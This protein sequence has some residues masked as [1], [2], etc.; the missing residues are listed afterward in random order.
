[1]PLTKE[2]LIQ[3]VLENVVG[4][5]DAIADRGV[6]SALQQFKPAMSP[7]AS[8]R[9]GVTGFR[10]QAGAAAAANQAAAQQEVLHGVDLGQDA[11]AASAQRAQQA[12]GVRNQNT[13]QAT[14]QNMQ[15]ANQEVLNAHALDTSA[16]DA[17]QERAN[18]AD[19]LRGVH[20]SGETRYR[21]GRAFT[22]DPKSGWWVPEVSLRAQNAVEKAKL[23]EHDNKT[24]R[25]GNHPDD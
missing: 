8:M 9:Q 2:G 13:A 6:Q 11:Q 19:A 18:H 12:A 5:R 24:K 7:I 10:N 25:A 3:S 23:P 21:N 15:A 14:S 16:Q 17:A 1:M 22:M 4:G 20:I